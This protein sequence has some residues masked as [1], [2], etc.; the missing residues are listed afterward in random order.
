M[1]L[2]FTA[3]AAIFCATGALLFAAGNESKSGEL[4]ILCSNGARTLIEE[5]RPQIERAAGRPISVDFSSS[6]SFKEKIDA[7]ATFDIAILTPELIDGLSKQGKILPGTRADIARSGVGIGVRAGMPKPDISTPEKLKQTL[8]KTKSI[9]F[10]KNG[11]SAATV[12]KMFDRLGITEAVKPHLI[13]ETQAG[14]V[15]QAVAEGQADMVLTLTSEILPVHGVQYVGPLPRELQSYIIM[16]AGVS[17]Q[18][19]NAES[20]KAAVKY[21]ASSSIEPAL[22]AKGLEPVLSK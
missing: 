6:A 1:K 18:S 17:A 2:R 10:T 21:L 14:R 9:T 3:S 7:G 15:S 12:N 11:A 16:S 22:K 5:L 19:K 4:H 20:A 8:L 13:L